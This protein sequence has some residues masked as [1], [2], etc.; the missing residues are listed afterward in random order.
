ML[1]GL[2][3]GITAVLVLLQRAATWLLARQRR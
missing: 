1:F 3:V 2:A